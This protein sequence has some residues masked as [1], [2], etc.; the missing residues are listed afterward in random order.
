MTKIYTAQERQQFLESARI[1][2]GILKHEFSEEVINECEARL[3]KV[4]ERVFSG[5]TTVEKEEALLLEK[6]N[7]LHGR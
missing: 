6:W 1:S 2:R 5:E 7:K 3:A 4:Y